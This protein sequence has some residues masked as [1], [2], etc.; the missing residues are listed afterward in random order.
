MIFKH[1][2]KNK[3]RGFLLNSARF[4]TS[5]V[6]PYYT[7]VKLLLRFVGSNGST[8]ISDESS[9]PATCTANNGAALSNV[10]TITGASTSLFLDGTN[11]RVSTD[12]ACTI[13]V[14]QYTFEA[15]V[16][17][18][19]ASR[20]IIADSQLVAT[21]AAYFIFVVEAD[22][23]VSHYLRNSANGGAFNLASS[24]GLIAMNDSIFQ[25]VA[26]TRNVSN[27]VNIWVDG[28]SVAS[29]TSATNPDGP[30]TW[31]IGA[32][33]AIADFFKGYQGII[34]LTEGV[35]RYTATFTPPSSF[36]NFPAV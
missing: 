16:R 6:D 15:L 23:S 9:T 8:T 29:G 26:V 10:R 3:Q 35:C 7:N 2:L 4:A 22:G 30:G 11:D 34:R 25:H 31:T 17:M 24:A 20:S 33:G 21:P 1:T 27:L 14:G 18:T 28:V 32:Q 5:P 36:N 19:G 12:R 13:G